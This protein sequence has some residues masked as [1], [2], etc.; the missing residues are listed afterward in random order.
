MNVPTDRVEAF[1]ELRGWSS[2]S[3]PGFPYAV[4]YENLRFPRVQLVIPKDAGA[5]DFDE[6]LERALL[7]LAALEK[8][9][10]D[11]I[12]RSLDSTRKG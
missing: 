3:L 8:L 9:D 7:K 12:R 5:P 2:R 1:L 4:A 10:I 6:S 11:I